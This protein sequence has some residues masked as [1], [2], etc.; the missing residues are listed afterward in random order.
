[1]RLTR[2]VA[3]CL[4]VGVVAS[5][6]AAQTTCCPRH[7]PPPGSSPFEVTQ[8]FPSKGPMQT[9][10][11]VH[12]ATATH[13]G[14]YITGAWF[15]RKPADP[16]IRILWD[17]RLSEIFVPYHT[18]EPRYYDLRDFEWPLVPL[19]RADAGCCGQLLSTAPGAD[20]VVVKEV[21]DRGPL[22]KD[23]EFVDGKLVGHVYRGEELALWSAM[24]AGNY[25]YLMEYLFRDDGSIGLRVGATARNLP[26]M[27]TIAHM[28][29]G[30]WRVDLDLAGF[31]N[32]SALIMSH[33]ETTAAKPATDTMTPFNGGTE[34][35]LDWNALEFTEVSVMDTVVKNDRGH[36]IQYDL[37]PMRGGSARHLEPFMHHDI[38]V[39]RYDPMELH[40]YELPKYVSAGRSVT[41]TDVVLWY[42]ASLHHLPRDEDGE[43]VDDR[44]K[45]VALLMWGGF[46]LRPRNFFRTTPFFP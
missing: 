19:T 5:P 7:T 45:G 38:W 35:F 26:G 22:W 39:T 37:M 21:R 27:E 29:N 31:P 12:W 11:L 17:A 18:G 2:V 3:I 40:Y 43:L 41:D 13:V 42:A 15:K 14:L 34:G 8:E 24:Q 16:W 9:A 25:E 36:Q 20:P 28:H 44:W 33:H 46:D 30:L 10:W 1:M 4:I 32:D 6:A 23:H